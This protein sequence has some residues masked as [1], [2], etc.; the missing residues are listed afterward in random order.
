MR[1]RL[2]VFDIDGTLT[3]TSAVDDACF[4][5]A[6]RSEWGVE[7]VSTDWEGYEHFSDNAIARQISRVHRGREATSAEL[8]ALRD[9]FAALIRQQSREH[10]ELFAEVPGSPTI[11]AALARDAWH[12]AIATGGWTPTAHHKL[13]TAGVPHRGVPAAFACDAEPRESIIRIAI[14]RAEAATGS[15]FDRIVYV[16]DGVWDARA[17]RQLAL[18]FVGVATGTRAAHLRREGAECLLEDFRDARCVLDAL[19]AATVPRER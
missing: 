9:R 6:V 17:C 3:R 19:D 4:V 13:D 18:P 8:A 14:A 15:T 1:A 5:D 16:G 10:P 11:F 12:T 7:G 2:A